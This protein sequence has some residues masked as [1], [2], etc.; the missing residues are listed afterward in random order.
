MERDIAGKI[1]NIA[2]ALSVFL[3]AGVFGGVEQQTIAAWKLIP[4]IILI[5]IIALAV[6]GLTKIKE[7]R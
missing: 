2:I 5:L 1:K 4:A 7:I 6:I 3:L